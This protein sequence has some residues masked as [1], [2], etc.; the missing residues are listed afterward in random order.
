MMTHKN[1]YENIE[2]RCWTEMYDWWSLRG[3]P[4]P[5]DETGKSKLRE[6]EFD[7]CI[8]IIEFD[9]VFDN[10]VLTTIN[11]NGIFTDVNWLPE[12]EI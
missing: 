8:E 11:D 2:S 5:T 9:T 10:G 1:F 7:T 6:E 4:P 12:V 3:C